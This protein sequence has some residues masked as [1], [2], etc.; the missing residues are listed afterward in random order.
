MTT[1]KILPIMATAILAGAMFFAGCEKENNNVEFNSKPTLAYGYSGSTLT[2]IVGFDVYLFSNDADVI[3][4]I[5][6]TYSYFLSLISDPDNMQGILSEYANVEN[7]F[8]N[9]ICNIY[10]DYANLSEENQELVMEFAEESNDA[11]GKIKGYKKFMK[12]VTKLQQERDQLA[13]TNQCMSDEEYIRRYNY[14]VEWLNNKNHTV[15]INPLPTN[16]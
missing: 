4:F 2:G 3:T 6:T 11:P 9:H 14:W 8:E 15:I 12:K 7:Y 1:H 16:S 5:D 10:P 13:N